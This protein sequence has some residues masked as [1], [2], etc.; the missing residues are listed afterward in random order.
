MRNA[1]CAQL[2]RESLVIWRN[3]YQNSKRGMK[4]CKIN[5]SFILKIEVNKF[6]NSSSTWRNESWSWKIVW[7]PKRRKAQIYRKNCKSCR[8]QKTWKL[9]DYRL[10]DPTSTPNQIQL[11]LIPEDKN[12]YF[13]LWL[14]GRKWRYTFPSHKLLGWNQL[15][16][17]ASFWKNRIIWKRMLIF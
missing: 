3:R 14:M 6:L 1:N 2:I 15:S 8:V 9:L 11:N 17:G 4:F 13:W 10:A 12:Q 16:G 5:W 7:Y